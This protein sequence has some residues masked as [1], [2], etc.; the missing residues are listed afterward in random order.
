[1]LFRSHQLGQYERPGSR[2][3][4]LWFP[5]TCYPENVII[6][7]TGIRNM[8]SIDY[9]K[10]I[11]SY[12]Q[13]DGHFTWSK[14]R[15]KIQV[16]QRAGCLS[17][18]GRIEIEVN[19]RCYQASRLAYAFMTGEW[20]TEQIDHINC[21]R[22]DNRWC[23]LRHATQSQNQANRPARKAKKIPLKGVTIK[24]RLPKP[25]IAQI[26]KDGKNTHLGCFST[27]EEAH[28]A[29]CNAAIDLHKEYWRG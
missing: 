21:I 11:L 24:S 5:L 8:D 7:Q 20:P 4:S 12:N 23:N 26:C 25:Y 19:G 13:E 28:K 14:P 17:K 22:H 6:V 9:L 18:K 2:Q 1:M 10:S 15:P 27:P 29:Y 16:G 3:I